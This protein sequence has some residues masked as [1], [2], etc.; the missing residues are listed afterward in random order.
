VG[1]FTVLDGTS[2]TSPEAYSRIIEGSKEYFIAGADFRVKPQPQ[3]TDKDP[4]TNGSGVAVG[5]LLNESKVSDSSV[6]K[7]V[8]TNI[9]GQD[10]TAILLG[11][12]GLKYNDEK[13]MRFNMFFKDREGNFVYSPS[14]GDSWGI[15]SETTGIETL[16]NGSKGFGDDDF[17]VYRDNIAPAFS[18]TLSSNTGTSADYYKTTIAGKNVAFFKGVN[19]VKFNLTASDQAVGDKASGLKSWSLTVDGS[20]ISVADEFSPSPAGG[21][22]EP[23]NGK[24]PQSK[25]KILDNIK[26]TDAGSGLPANPAPG[27][28][29]TL[30]IALEDQLGNQAETTQFRYG[31]GS[32]TAE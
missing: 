23:Q 32:A 3:V 7:A 6:F 31:D 10:G 8:G 2:Q 25:D 12:D 17:Y 19:Q 4:D 18:A 14:A 9:E 28:F 1:G 27:D 16:P 21:E 24:N 22:G 29:S 20:S 26:N 30:A 15:V 11:S 13:Y 5:V